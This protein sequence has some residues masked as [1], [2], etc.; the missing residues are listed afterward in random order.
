MAKTN[1]KGISLVELKKAMMSGSF[2]ATKTIAYMKDFANN[3]INEETFVE[4]LRKLN[5]EHSFIYGGNV[6]DIICSFHELTS[7][8]TRRQ[9]E[10]K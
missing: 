1:K 3:K 8:E 10:A 9:F 5:K 7:A 6:D 4:Q 2:T